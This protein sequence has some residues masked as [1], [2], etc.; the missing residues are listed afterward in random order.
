MT[1]PATSPIAHPVRQCIV[2]LNAVRLNEGAG[3]IT[4]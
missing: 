3:V 2:A 4:D 1:M